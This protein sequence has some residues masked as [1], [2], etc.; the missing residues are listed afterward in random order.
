ML[1][2]PIREIRENKTLAKMFTYTLTSFIFESHAH[3]LYCISLFAK[4]KPTRKFPLIQSHPLFVPGPH[5]KYHYYKP[6]HEIRENK[7]LAKIST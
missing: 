4:I 6:I 3:I 1:S 7:T 2:K 5:L